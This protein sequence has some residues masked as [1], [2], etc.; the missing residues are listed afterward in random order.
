MLIFQDSIPRDNFRLRFRSWDSTNPQCHQFFWKPKNLPDS[1]DYENAKQ[2]GHNP[3][4][5]EQQD[6]ARCAATTSRRLSRLCRGR[7]KTVIG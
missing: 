5:T 7:R 3:D 1:M 6:S 2:S 4:D